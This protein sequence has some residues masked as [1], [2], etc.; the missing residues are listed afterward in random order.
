MARLEDLETFVAIVENGSLTAAA[1]RLGRP[2][3]SVSRSLSVLEQDVGV[4]LARR[5]TRR[6]SPTEAGLTFYNRVKP[7]VAEIEEAKLQAGNRRIEA[8]GLLR[9]GAPV[10]FAPAYIVPA[11][12]EYMSRHP[13]V[14]VDLK[15]SDK[16][17]DLVE[18]KLDLAIRIGDLPDADLKARRFGAL[19]RVFFGA[20]SY[21][22]K[23]GR[24]EH[25]AALVEHQCVV[26]SVSANDSRWPY[27]DGNTV[28]SIR[29]SGRFRADHG[30]SMYAA[31]AAGLG[32][33]FTPLW[34]IRQLVDEGRV[35]L[36][37]I[38]H[39]PP[40]VPIHVVWQGGKLMPAKTRLLIDT[41]ARRLKNARL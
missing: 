38:D 31:V 1:K 14:E 30:A 39:E 37:L 19:R 26:R 41:L 20:P 21:F 9:V 4:E 18:E 15:L 34:Q 16:F 32:I 27:K 28:K 24:P 13:R 12:V 40:P 17:V 29:V 6:M 2:L 3:Q 35:E 10:F 33:G 8:T 23:H 11:A 7:A 22:E 25:P 36:I 5:T